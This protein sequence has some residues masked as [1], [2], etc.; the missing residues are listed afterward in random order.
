M[1][2]SSVVLGVC[3]IGLLVTASIGVFLSFQLMQN[4]PPDFQWAVSINDEFMYTLI[5]HGENTTFEYVPEN[6]SYIYYDSPLSIGWSVSYCN[7]EYELNN[8]SGR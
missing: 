8:K 6:E 3:A 7:R 5:I 1:K 2:R 4:Q